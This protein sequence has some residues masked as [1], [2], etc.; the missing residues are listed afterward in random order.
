MFLLERFTY[1]SGSFGIVWPAV[2]G[3]PACDKDDGIA[4]AAAIVL[5]FV[6]CDTLRWVV[7]PVPVNPQG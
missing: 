4:V 7:R 1:C 5:P 2:L 6:L 3:V